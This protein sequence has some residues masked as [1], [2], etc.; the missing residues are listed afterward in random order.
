MEL[1]E[2]ARFWEVEQGMLLAIDVGNTQTAVGIF[3]GD[4][5]CCHW[6]IST[7][8]E[9]TADELAITLANL[10]GLENLN[11]SDINAIIISSVVPHCTISLAEMAH[12]NLR[13]EPL[14]VGP[15]VRT[16]IP[17][18]Y[19]NPHEVG[20]DRIA[21]AVAAYELYEGPV[22]VVDFGTATTFDAISEKGE[23]LG[24]AIAPGV[25]VAAQALFSA[26]AK[27]SGVELVRPPSPIGK[28]TQASLQSGIIFGS[29]GLVDTLVRRIKKEMGDNPKV[30]A[31]GGLAELMAPECETIDEV[32]PLLTLIGLKKIYDK[33]I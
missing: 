22:I 25:E 28:N 26:A 9:E 5:L 8:K 24:G 30:V 20:A 21:N 12:K 31:T 32:N 33:N 18:L 1:L 23:Y 13:L 14:I 16:G 10:L 7:N 17:I 6:R 2:R 29:A 27:L 4:E 3:K 15:G 11:L 19:D